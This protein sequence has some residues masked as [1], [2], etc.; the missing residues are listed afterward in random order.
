MRVGRERVFDGERNAKAQ[1]PDKSCV[2]GKVK[3]LSVAKA[4]RK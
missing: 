4:G 3:E 2:F 1:R